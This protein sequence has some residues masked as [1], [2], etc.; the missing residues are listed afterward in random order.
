MVDDVKNR[1]HSGKSGE[2]NPGVKTLDSLNHD[3][4]DP[5]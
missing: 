1:K 4:V 3:Y 5:T 2:G